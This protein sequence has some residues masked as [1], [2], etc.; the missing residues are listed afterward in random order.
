MVHYH[1]RDSN[2]FVLLHLYTS[3]HNYL[4]I[5]TYMYKVLTNTKKLPV[6]S[7]RLSNSGI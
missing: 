1:V 2:V 4:H 7:T 5:T 3:Q 6:I